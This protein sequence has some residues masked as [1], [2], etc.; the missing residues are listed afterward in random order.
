MSRMESHAEVELRKAGLYDADADYGGAIAEAVMK[1]VR[2]HASE[3]H[4]G[5]SHHMTLS[6][7][8]KVI[9]FKTLSPITSSPDEWTEVAEDLWQNRRQSS[10]FSKDGGKTWYDLDE[11]KP[12]EA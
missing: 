11:P 12:P 4:S 9:N 2:A 6:I 8:N 10:T 5:G 3:E 7:F 1:L